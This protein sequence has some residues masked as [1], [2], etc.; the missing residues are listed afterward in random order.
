[1]RNFFYAFMHM[2]DGRRTSILE[3]ILVICC[4]TTSSSHVFFSFMSIVKISRHMLSSF[5][6]SAC[7][8]ES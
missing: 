4:K 6:E 1:M 8:L 5:F 2:V 7:W 3:Q